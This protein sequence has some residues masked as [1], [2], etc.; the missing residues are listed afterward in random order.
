MNSFEID[1]NVVNLPELAGEI[2]SLPSVSV[3]GY[4]PNGSA[5]GYYW[6]NGGAWATIPANWPTGESYPN[7]GG[8]SEVTATYKNPP[9]GAPIPSV[10]PFGGQLEQEYGPCGQ[11]NNIHSQGRVGFACTP[12]GWAVCAW[13][14]PTNDNHITVSIRQ[15][16]DG[17]STW[18]TPWV[19]VEK[20]F[21]GVDV[22][23]DPANADAIIVVWAGTDINGTEGTINY[24][25]MNFHD[26]HFSG[27]IEFGGQTALGAP[28]VTVNG[29]QTFIAW[30][31]TDANHSVNVMT[32]TGSNLTQAKCPLNESS[33][34][35]PRIRYLEFGAGSGKIF[36]TYLGTDGEL[37]ILAYDPNTLNGTKNIIPTQFSGLDAPA[38]EGA[39]GYL[40]L[41]FA[42]S[43]GMPWITCTPATSGTGPLSFQPL[44]GL[45]TPV[46]F[47]LP[48]WG[49]SLSWDIVSGYGLQLGFEALPD[50]TNGPM[51]PGQLTAGT[52]AV[53]AVSLDPA[54]WLLPPWV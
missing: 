13:S 29:N 5:I 45:L 35:S 8:V 43:V 25:S 24:A 3:T 23:F 16:I 46:N 32:L 21:T 40:F 6:T 42:D 4:N 49:I 48:C 50:G 41:C 33:N 12:Q 52:P 11:L 31:G 39:A 10:G 2:Y 38:V 34:N 17:Y 36:L 28:A 27:K 54:Q 26:Q 1:Y 22:C 53:K 30:T 47:P 14:D 51:L 20:S 44:L 15:Q 9:A 18:S 7:Q 37:N 19:S